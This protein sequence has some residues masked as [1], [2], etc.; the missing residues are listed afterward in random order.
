M[1]ILRHKSADNLLPL[2]SLNKHSDFT[3]S[4]TPPKQPINLSKWLIESPGHKTVW[5]DSNVSEKTFP[6]VF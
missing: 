2:G 6:Q 1:F 5:V 3:V 4:E